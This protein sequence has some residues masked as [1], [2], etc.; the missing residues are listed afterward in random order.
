FCVNAQFQGVEFYGGLTGFGL[1]AGALFR[2]DAVGFGLFERHLISL[3]SWICLRF[4]FPL[5]HLR[6]STDESYSFVE[7]SIF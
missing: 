4:D 1:R 7:S 2:V 3:L 6:Q 5:A